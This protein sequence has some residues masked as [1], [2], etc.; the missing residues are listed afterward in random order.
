MLVDERRRQA[1]QLNLR[2]FDKLDL[3]ETVDRVSRARRI[4]A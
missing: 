1:E 4:Y 3:P 2:V